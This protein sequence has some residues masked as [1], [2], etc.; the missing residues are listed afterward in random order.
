MEDLIQKFLIL[1]L[2]AGK[3]ILYESEHRVGATQSSNWAGKKSRND[4]D[5][6][7][8]L[9]CEE[10]RI[11]K[12]QSDKLIQSYSSCWLEMDP[13]TQNNR[14]ICKHAISIYCYY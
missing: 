13:S 5:R 14:Y 1:G 8:F 11:V 4:P 2:K 12:C 3:A 9:V 10:Y 7:T 6:T